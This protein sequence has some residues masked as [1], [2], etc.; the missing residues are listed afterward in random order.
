MMK[1]IGSGNFEIYIIDQLDQLR[2]ITNHPSGDGVTG[3]GVLSLAWSPDGSQ[4]AFVSDRD[5]SF[6]IFVAS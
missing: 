4:I 1:I 3:I 5:G 6:D 2:N